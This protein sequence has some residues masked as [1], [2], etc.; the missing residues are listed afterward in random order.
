MNGTEIKNYWY[1]KWVRIPF[2]NIENPPHYEVSNYGRVCSYSADSPQGKIIQGSVI[3]GYRSLNLRMKGGKTVNQYIHKLVAKFF[4][5]PGSESQSYVIHLD[6]DKQNN[7]AENLKWVTRDEMVTHNRVNPAVV[8]KV[9]PRQT[10]NYKLNESKVIMIKRLLK[11]D[12]SRHKMIAKQFGITH[13]QLNRI[14]VGE[15]WKHVRLQD[16]V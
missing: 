6:F 4:I 11:S 13:T 9:M 2:D 10:K 3:Q 12:K 15:N 5:T 16:D 7:R 8:N 1:E 14:K